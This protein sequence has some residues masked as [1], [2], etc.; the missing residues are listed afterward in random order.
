MDQAVLPAAPGSQPEWG[1]DQVDIDAYFSR[2]GYDGPRTATFETLRDIHRAH[3]DSIT[4]EIIDMALNRHVSLDLKSV[5]KKIVEDGQGGCCLESNLLFAAVLERLGFSVVRHIARVR[6]GNVSNIR[7]RSHAVLLVEIDGA[8]W[9]ADPGFGDESPLEPVRFEDGATL[10]VGDWTWRLDLE[11]AEWILRCKHADGWFDVYALR[12]ERHH[13]VDFDMIN[14]FSYAD[15]NS[16]F[17]G[18]L[19][20]QRGGEKERRVLKDHVLVTQHADG[21]TESTELTGDQIVQELRT[22]FNITL[23]D[24]DAAELRERFGTQAPTS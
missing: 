21:R 7:T 3:A 13:M 20:V 15:P 11:G 4:W 2:I 22:T 19:V 1:I 5:Q 12:L 14:H 6:R 23:R 16:V 9:M 10:T 24:A 17:V 8:L 18:R